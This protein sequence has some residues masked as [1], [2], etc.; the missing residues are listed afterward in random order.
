MSSRRIRQRGVVVLAGAV[1]LGGTAACRS[2]DRAGANRADTV[3]ASAGTSVS[4]PE[5]GEWQNGDE[6]LTFTATRRDSLT[7]VTELVTFGTDGTARRTFT[8]GPRGDLRAFTESRTQTVQAGDRSPTRMQVDWSFRVAGDSVVQRVKRIDGAP[9]E[10]RDYEISSARAHVRDL[11]AA[12]APPSGM[13]S[14][15]H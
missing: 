4:L 2:A 1:L 3:G 5:S 13:P 12:M 14:S 6:R 10:V 11:L 9:A 15:R 7:D 8:V